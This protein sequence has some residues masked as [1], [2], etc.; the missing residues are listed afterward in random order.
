MTLCVIGG[1][2]D[3]KTQVEHFGKMEKEMPRLGRYAQRFGK[4]HKIHTWFVPMA[5]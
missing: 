2:K 5:S 3:G 4:V 1:E